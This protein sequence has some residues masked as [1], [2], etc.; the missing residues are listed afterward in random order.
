MKTI[1]FVRFVLSLIGFMLILWCTFS[2]YN[3]EFKT[4]FESFGAT[5]FILGV[6][7]DFFTKLLVATIVPWAVMALAYVFD[8]IVRAIILQTGIWT[9]KKCA[10]LFAWTFD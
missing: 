3:G 5:L 6:M 8:D 7:P 10:K 4:I 1:N 9:I 2:R